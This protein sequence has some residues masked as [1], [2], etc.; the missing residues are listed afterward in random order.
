VQ[1]DASAVIWKILEIGAAVGQLD[2]HLSDNPRASVNAQDQ[3]PIDKTLRGRTDRFLPQIPEHEQSSWPSL[4]RHHVVAAV[5]IG[6]G[7]R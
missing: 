1:L 2:W 3:A 6:K 5:A 4:D 7:R